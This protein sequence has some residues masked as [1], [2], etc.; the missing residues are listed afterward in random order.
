MLIFESS[1]TEVKGQPDS[2]V[3][4]VLSGEVEELGRQKYREEVFVILE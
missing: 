1:H 4:A 2:S 3:G